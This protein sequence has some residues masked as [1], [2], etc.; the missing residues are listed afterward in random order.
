MKSPRPRSPTLVIVTPV[1]NEGANIERYESE[2]LACLAA[3]SGMEAHFILVDDG[4]SDDSWMRIEALARRSPRF[5]GIRL[6]RNFGAHAALT[7]GFDHVGDDA[8]IVASLACDLQ[9]PVET[10]VSF[11]AAWRDGADV[12]WG[13]R[14]QR[15]D[16]WWRAAASRTLER[17]LRRHAMPSGSKFQTGSFFLIDRTVLNCFRQFREHSRVTFALVAWTGFDQATV[18]YDR[19]AR[20]IGTSGW[21]FGRMLATAYDVFIGFSPLPARFMTVLGL[22][23]FGLSVLTQFYLVGEWFVRKVAPG[24]TGIM[25]TMTFF[26][27]LLFMMMGLVTEYLYRIFVETKDR[28]IYFV[29]EKSG[30]LPVDHDG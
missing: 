3:S 12:V 28:P 18:S 25:A 10:I 27:G 16:V 8:D 29:S 23:I 11:V 1:Y 4:S 26:F 9:D 2:V 21:S 15:A 7:A 17:V 14:R 19:R 24:W 30:S 22:F 5:S 20:V 6:S 13:S